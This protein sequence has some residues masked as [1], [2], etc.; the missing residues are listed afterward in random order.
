[1]KRAPITLSVFILAWASTLLTGCVSLLP[2]GVKHGRVR[3]AGRQAA[4]RLR[5]DLFSDGKLHVVILGSGTP[6]AGANRLPQSTA[7]IA[8]DR[9]IVVDAGEGAGRQIADLGLPLDRIT[10]VFITHFHSDHI[11]GLGQLLNQSWNF[12]RRQAVTVHGPTG[13]ESIMQGFAQVYAPDISYR[14]ANVVEHNDPALALA[15]V[16]T[17]DDLDPGAPRI[18]VE[19]GPLTVAAFRVDHGHVHPAVGYR[20]TYG[21]RTVV[22]SGDTVA[23]PLMVEAARGADLLLHEAL[24]A[25][26]VTEGAKGL[27]AAGLPVEADRA[28]AVIGY[29][30]DT[31]AL[32][33]IAREA[34]V[35]HL[36]LTHL[37][38][39]PPHRT[40][41]RLFVD[42]MSDRF[43]GRITV[44]RDGMEFCLEP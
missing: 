8:G 35:R 1:M 43:D 16:A 27:E 20:I 5:H 24:N 38:P 39:V 18:L 42:G 19:D 29:H 37:I 26:M 32:A 25:M 22:V 11:G 17:F 40:A 13:L 15:D 36:V 4:E 31:L 30:A 21:N 23:S 6:Q 33:D 10:D 12:G 28:R 44:A 14:A 34:G 2:E 7:I 41:E 9:F 3:R